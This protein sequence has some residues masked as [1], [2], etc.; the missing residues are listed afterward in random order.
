MTTCMGLIMLSFEIF[1][2]MINSYLL[3][4]SYQALSKVF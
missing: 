2:C 4:V 1:I 3:R